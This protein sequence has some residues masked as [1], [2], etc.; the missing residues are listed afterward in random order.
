MNENT[1]RQRV[2]DAIRDGKPDLVRKLY[3][4]KNTRPKDSIY[5][6]TF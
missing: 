2:I 5:K 1:N 6:S 3:R 4:D